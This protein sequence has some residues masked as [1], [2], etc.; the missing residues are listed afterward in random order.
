MKIKIPFGKFKNKINWFQVLNM[1]KYYLLSMLHL[2]K[3]SKNSNKFW[4]LSWNTII[5]T[6]Y[7]S[8]LWLGNILRRV[9]P[10]WSHKMLE[11]SPR[12]WK[13]FRFRSRFLSIWGIGIKCVSV[14]PNK[15]RSTFDRVHVQRF[16]PEGNGVLP[17]MR[18][19]QRT[20][21]SG[22]FPVTTRGT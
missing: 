5:S 22:Q 21:V 11:T 12:F 6:N 4:K 3:S 20:K 1:F 16:L 14:V 13:V 19:V 10:V 2:F 7:Y 15:H 8:H 18:S 9:R 17:R